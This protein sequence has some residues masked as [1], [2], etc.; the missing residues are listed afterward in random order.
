MKNVGF[1]CIII[2]VVANLLFKVA[3]Y[4]LVTILCSLVYIALL[5]RP[6]RLAEVAHALLKVAPYDPATMGCRGL[7]RYMNEILPYPD[8][9]REDLRPALLNIL[10]RLDKMFNKIA[11]NSSI[12]VSLRHQWFVLGYFNYAQLDH[13]Y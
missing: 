12:R 4:E 7:R 1:Y 8:W 6:Q 5:I 9:S 13:R 3:P 2:F 10:R 11:K